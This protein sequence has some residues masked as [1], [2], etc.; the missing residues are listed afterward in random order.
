LKENKQVYP[1]DVADELG[2]K[3]ELVKE[4]FDILE[5]EERLKRRGG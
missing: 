4:I 2:L 1:S 5:K 3:Y